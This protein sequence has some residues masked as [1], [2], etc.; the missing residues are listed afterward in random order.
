MWYGTTLFIP[1]IVGMI[2]F[3]YCVCVML[4]F[5][6]EKLFSISVDKVLEKMKICNKT[7]N[8]N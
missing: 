7:I 2:I 6:R 4:D 5:I 8:V 3:I 1:K